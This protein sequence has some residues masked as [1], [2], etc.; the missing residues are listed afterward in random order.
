[1]VLPGIIP[2]LK[3][4]VGT[5][6]G[7]LAHLMAVIYHSVR[8]LPAGHPYLSPANAG[9]FGIR[10]VIAEARNNLVF[11]KENI[12]QIIVFFAILAGFVVLVLQFG[13]LLMALV[14]KPAFA[15]AAFAGLFA[16][17]APERDIA[18]ML[19]DSVFGIPDL[20]NSCIAL[21]IPCGPTSPAPQA[22]PTPFQTG[23]HNLFHFYNLAVLLL[24][25]LIFLYYVLIMVGETAQTGTPFGRRFNHVWAPL[26][27]VVA[28]GLLVPIN[29][30]L[31]SAQYMTLFA[32]KYGSGFATNGWLLFNRSLS[33]ALGIQDAS[34]I[35]EPAAPRATSVVQYMATVRACKVA[36]ETL[37]DVEIKPY[38]VKAPEEREEVF[39]G[40][41]P[42]W[43]TAVESFYNYDDITIRFGHYGVDENGKS[44]YPN[45]DGHVKPLC[46]EIRVHTKDM[47]YEGT[48]VAQEGYYKW[49][50]DMWYKDD[51]DDL[52]VRFGCI[53]LNPRPTTCES[54][55]FGANDIQDKPPPSEWKQELITEEVDEVSIIVENAY[56]AMRDSTDFTVPQEILERGWGG[57]GIWYNRIAQWNGALFSAIKAVPSPVMMPSAMEAARE[58]RRTYDENVDAMNMYEPYLRGPNDV[59]FDI[60][61]EIQIASELSA[62]YQYWRTSNST[63]PVELQSTGNVL[64]DLLNR[65]FGM[66]GLYDIRQNDSIHPLAQLVSIGKSIVES[67]INNL[68]SSLV[69]AAAGGGATEIMGPHIGGAINS[70]S[71]FYVALAT[72]GLSIGFVLYYVLP[73]LPFI[74]F[75]FAVGAWVK[76]IFEA[77][78]G[79]PLWALAHLK[80]DGNG[81]PGDTAMNGYFLIFEIF[82][83]PILTVFG[84]L[85][86][87]VIFSAMARTL[88]GIFSLVVENMTGFDCVGCNNAVPIIADIEFKRNIVDEFFFTVLY[89]IIVYLMATSSFKLVDQIPNGIL[90]WMGAGVQSFGDQRDDPAA[91]LVQY[92]AFGGANISGQ[93]IGAV[94]QGAQTAGMGA[95]AAAKGLAEKMKIEPQFQGASTG[96]PG[97][98]PNKPGQA[99]LTGKKP[100][101]DP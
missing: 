30:G 52:A 100:P 60:D 57:A 13:L 51:Y 18:L 63:D 68:M 6:F 98:T 50:V 76:T 83:R 49:V 97:G 44:L 9:R 82:V 59:P 4:L 73:F 62:V 34:L 19:L 33:N 41:S 32:A 37:S 47:A 86:S 99:G 54:V 77:M 75:F 14:F 71:S 24:G 67:S 23:L 20:Y 91:N 46:G 31:N 88:N 8:L 79:V 64:F 84:L 90:R 80:V 48:R 29:Y 70:M 17:P 11:K 7:W 87:V 22:F 55:S 26:R 94:Q 36:Y 58:A 56:I 28:V 93:V 85:A 72:M 96:G 69:L 61:N 5:G 16:T 2:R 92:A 43:R 15:A 38:L 39:V 27:L 1:M 42:D 89:T 95:G 40:P 53:H 74:Y 25:V 101:S 35:A 65:L 45:E 81:L 78:V 10:H 12:D 66:D 3:E 21:S